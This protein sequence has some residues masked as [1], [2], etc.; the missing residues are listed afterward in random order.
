MGKEI[1]AQATMEVDGSDKDGTAATMSPPP[2]ESTN[3]NNAIEAFP[4]EAHSTT[5]N[6][7]TPSQ[8]QLKDA[9]VSTTSGVKSSSTVESKSTSSKEEMTKSENREVGEDTLETTDNNTEKVTEDKVKSPSVSSD[10][11]QKD[12]SKKATEDQSQIS[13][14]TSDSSQ[15]DESKKAA[16]ELSQNPSVSSDPNETDTTR[17][18][19][20][21]ECKAPAEMQK[22]AGS[23]VFLPSLGVG[24]TQTQSNEVTK[25]GSSHV[26]ALE[27]SKKN[28]HV[29]SARKKENFETTLPREEA[30]P[31]ASSKINS[32]R[33][34]R[35]QN[36]KS[37]IGLKT[38]QE[39]ITEDG[40]AK[41]KSEATMASVVRHDKENSD[42]ARQEKKPSAAENPD[43]ERKRQI[44]RKYKANLSDS[45]I[46]EEAAGLLARI[47]TVPTARTRKAA[48]RN[49]EP[50][51]GQKRSKKDEEQGNFPVPV[52]IRATNTFLFKWIIP[53]IL[54][55]L[56]VIIA[57]ALAIIILDRFS[58]TD[59]DWSSGISPVASIQR[60]DD[61]QAYLVAH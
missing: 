26:S 39:V 33:P 2:A 35:S 45:Q 10:S 8:S 22:E 16:E 47:E 51:S 53:I 4:Q 42:I 18:K 49:D 57:A 43:K 34:A 17:M 61:I 37:E 15:K 27:S 20:N 25:I 40:L 60:L 59:D 44:L 1:I 6:S 28:T 19:F 9:A 3:E 32:S 7:P 54:I 29:A 31:T 13:S 46:R 24:P 30:K 36:S 55:F 58:E 12:E 52:E 23:D 56:L 48:M 21:Q 5:E 11:S 50:D 38:I 14:A 41:S